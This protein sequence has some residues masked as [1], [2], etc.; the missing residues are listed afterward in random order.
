MTAL[1][2]YQLLVRDFSLEGELSPR[3]NLG[4]S[5]MITSS[6]TM[7][8]EQNPRPQQELPTKWRQKQLCAGIGAGSNSSCDHPCSHFCSHVWAVTQ[9]RRGAD[10]HIHLG[11]RRAARGQVA[12]PTDFA[13]RVPTRS[14]PRG[15][16]FEEQLPP[17]M[18]ISRHSQPSYFACCLLPGR[19]VQ[20][21]HAAGANRTRGE[22]AL[23][24]A[25]SAG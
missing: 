18:P 9:P 20:A 1:P 22:R 8:R 17:W 11:T 5:I 16:D 12:S 19:L 23:R 4:H 3:R 13:V 2:Y 25:P 21:C 15:T 24:A 6:P 10:G 7:L 14:Q